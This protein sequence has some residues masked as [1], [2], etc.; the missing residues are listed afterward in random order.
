MSYCEFKDELGSVFNLLEQKEIGEWTNE[1]V[2]KFLEQINEKEFVPIFRSN[3]I[4]GAALLKIRRNDLICMGITA[5]G[6]LIRLTDQFDKL[7][8]FN[9]H[10][11][12]LKFLKGRGLIAA[13]QISSIENKFVHIF[14][15]QLNQMIEEGSKE[16]SDSTIKKIPQMQDKSPY[17]NYNSQSLEEAESVYKSATVRN[18]REVSPSRQAR[19]QGP[20]SFPPT[21]Y[22]TSKINSRK[23]GKSPIN[24][25]QDS[26]SSSSSS[27]SSASR[28][29]SPKPHK[30]LKDGLQA[31]SNFIIKRESI[32]FQRWLQEGAYGKVFLGT[33]NC[34]PVAVKVFKKQRN[35]KF[36]IHSFLKEVRVISVLTHPNILLYIGVCL[37]KDNCL[38]ISE[39][40]ENGSLYDH[41]H[42]KKTHFE[43]AQI[44]QFII[45]IMK[46]MAYVHSMGFLHC[47]I[48]S[49]NILLDA[50]WNIKLADFGLSKQ[51]IGKFDNKKMRIGTPNWMAPEVCRGESY[52]KAADVYSFGLV[53]WEILTH[54][55]PHS[56]EHHN[57]IFNKVGYCN[58][59]PVEIPPNADPL[60]SSLIVKCL[61]FE[62]EKRP[63]FHEML[64][65]LEKL[66]YE[67]KSK[68]N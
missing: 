59:L 49:S 50:Q 37:H 45:E 52:T 33:Y 34:L 9:D 24:T 10:E 47:D 29:Q 63:T 54:R 11:T 25:Y 39:Y 62:K 17:P 43:Q 67:Q 8:K 13:N 16:E 61:Q 6:D 44:M 65:P 20:S 41:I 53:L 3:N 26:K 38:M 35:S 66:E 21:E 36:H 58:K 7:I 55:I 23:R 19:R 18:Q 48:K 64:I 32:K 5:K 12:R 14:E 40:L 60:I 15:K 27:S 2:L 4:T 30:K 1:E 68:N 42:H 46:A 57:I 28:R 56:G 22:N 51:I 31:I